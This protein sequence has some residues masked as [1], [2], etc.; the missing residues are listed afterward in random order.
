M[1][2]FDIILQGLRNEK[3]PRK[4]TPAD[5][6]QMAEE[7]FEKKTKPIYSQCVKLCV[8]ILD[9][10]E[11][12]KKA[13]QI[14]SES[15]LD[16][17]Q[18]HYQIALQM[19]R[20]FSE[21]TPQVLSSITLPKVN[22]YSSFSNFHSKSIEILS[23]I[24]QIT[25]DNRYLPFFLSAEIGTFGKHMNE[26][27]RFTEEF[28]VIL[29][30][31]RTLNEKIIHAKNLEKRLQD[32]KLELSH[33]EETKQSLSRQNDELKIKISSA[34]EKNKAIEVEER[35]IKEEIE[36]ILMQ[37]S[38]NK[39]I[40]SDMLSPFQ[41]QFRKM[42]KL[43]VDKKQAKLL[44]EYVNQPDV[45]IVSEFELTRDYTG[46]KQLLTFMKTALQEGKLEDD[47]KVRSRRIASINEILGGSLIKSVEQLSGL[48]EELDN[49]DYQKDTLSKRKERLDL[50]NEE[51]IQNTEKISKNEKKESF[52]KEELEKC[53]SNLVSV[54][55]ELSGEKIVLKFS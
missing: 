8:S 52:T 12:A 3:Q 55:E 48:S 24:T 30:P 45:T 4:L 13:A 31:S 15:E 9:E 34:T 16:K 35:K 53:A 49:L 25:H 46:L 51:L 32:L 19:Q 18:Q 40:I 38:N 22:S 20:N 54:V 27:A 37:I 23:K 21:R 10:L 14:V 43:F 44:E 39:K 29:E 26:I 11:K 50:L 28:G 6:V 2:L 36:K 7:V 1:G 41:R 42:Q 47:P 33:L 17:D 5:A